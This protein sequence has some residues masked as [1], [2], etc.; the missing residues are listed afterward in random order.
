MPLIIAR[1]WTGVGLSIQ[2]PDYQLS[3]LRLVFSGLLPYD[4]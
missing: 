4:L 3:R 1:E 2:L